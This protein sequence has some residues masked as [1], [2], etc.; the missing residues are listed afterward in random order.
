LELQ[1][2]PKSGFPASRGQ[3]QGAFW[4]RAFWNRA[5]WRTDCGILAW[6]P[7]FMAWSLAGLKPFQKQGPAKSKRRHT[8]RHAGTWSDQKMAGPKPAF[9]IL[10]KSA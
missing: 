8:Q 10:V 1:A 7:V 5:Y 9:L 3:R 6:S 2:K 4:N